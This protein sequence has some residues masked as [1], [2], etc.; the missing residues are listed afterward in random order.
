[1]V[2]VLVAA[3]ALGVPN[4]VRGN[5]RRREGGQVRQEAVVGMLV[6]DDD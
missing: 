6:S 4:P 1:V 3:I 2:V 5:K